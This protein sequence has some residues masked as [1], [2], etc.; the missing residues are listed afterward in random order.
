MIHFMHIARPANRAEHRHRQPAAQML[1]EFFQAG[2]QSALRKSGQSNLKPKSQQ[3]VENSIACGLRQA[4]CQRGIHRVDR[5]A[6]RDRF[7][8]P[9]LEIGQ[10]LPACGRSSGQN[11]TAGLPAF[12]TDRRRA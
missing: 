1:A 9:H 5:H 3:A 6:N 7:A 12:R 10:R 2:E 11:P 4:K 8:V